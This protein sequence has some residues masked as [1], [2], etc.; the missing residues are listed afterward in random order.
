M[1]KFATMIFGFITTVLLPSAPVVQNSTNK[2]EGKALPAFSMK[3]TDGKTLN[4][5]NTAGKVVLFD[6]WATWCGPCKAA[7]PTMQS[8]HKQFSS[9]GL[10]VIGA[11]TMEEDAGPKPA[12]DYKKQ[13]SYTY[14]FTYD[15]DKLTTAWGV[16]GIP[17]FVLRDRKGKVVKT[18]FGF[19]ESIKADIVKVTTATVKAR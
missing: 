13:H 6:F 7:S 4:N 17:Q 1:L 10:L 14:T 12:A 11:D 19:N 5:A 2:M 8:L 18:W 3:T 9:K 16:R 15:N